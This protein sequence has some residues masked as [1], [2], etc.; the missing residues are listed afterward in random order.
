V[1][2]ARR[3]KLLGR[4]RDAI[5]RFL[6]PGERPVAATLAL[7]GLSPGAVVVLVGVLIVGVGAATVAIM[8]LQGGIV[9]S[10]L[11][12][13]MIG[14]TVAAMSILSARWIVVTDRRLIILRLSLR[15]SEPRELERAD[16]LSIVRVASSHPRWGGFDRVTVG[17]EGGPDERLRSAR[18]WAG[19]LAAVVTALT[20]PP[21]PSSGTPPIPPPP[22]P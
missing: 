5:P 7:V 1:G 22:S 9:R 18:L 21:P 14:G 3:E 17:R 6:E 8:V 16:P 19:D 10:A 20:V 11:V 13:G 4:L 15:N 2:Q 12:G